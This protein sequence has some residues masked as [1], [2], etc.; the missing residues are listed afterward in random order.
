[1]Q[2]S[3]RFMGVKLEKIECDSGNQ[4]EN[5]SMKMILNSMGKAG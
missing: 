3:L 5:P 2:M 1:M 4:V